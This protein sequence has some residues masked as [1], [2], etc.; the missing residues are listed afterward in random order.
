[1]V[2]RQGISLY[3]KLGCV[4]LSL[5]KVRR[6]VVL[7]LFDFMR[8]IGIR[9]D[10]GYPKNKEQNG[11]WDAD[12]KPEKLSPIRKS[13]GDRLGGLN[14]YDFLFFVMLSDDIGDLLA[15]GD[16]NKFFNRSERRLKRSSTITT[17]V[18]A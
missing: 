7:R 4:C 9:L 15:K 1:I 10:A 11:D 16:A 13:S 17:K 6:D 3:F 8:K 14:L 12:E 2:F 18:V 5:L